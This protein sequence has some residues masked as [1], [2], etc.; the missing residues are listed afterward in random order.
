MKKII[1]F[2][3]IFVMAILSNLNAQGILSLKEDI[4]GKWA[5]IDARFIDAKER[6][7]INMTPK[8]IEN[9]KSQKELFASL[10]FEFKDGKMNTIPKEGPSRPYTLTGRYLDVQNTD[11]KD[12]RLDIVK[13]NLEM[14]PYPAEN[15]ILLLIIF[16]KQ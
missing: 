3:A 9:L 1:L 10:A 14:A 7:P 4:I 8:L 13:G 6:K 11:I 2:S 15:G 12:V 5:M 16:K